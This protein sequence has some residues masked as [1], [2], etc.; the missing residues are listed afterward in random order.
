MTAAI[1]KHAWN[2]YR[3]N[4]G[5]I[6]AVIL[7]ICLPLD[8]LISYMG[9]FVFDPYITRKS[10]IFAQFLEKSLGLLQLQALFLL[11]TTGVADSVLLF[12]AQ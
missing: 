6:A 1:L 10:F 11:G 7:A 3:S 8:L 4:F 12:E 9:Y 5:V 2:L